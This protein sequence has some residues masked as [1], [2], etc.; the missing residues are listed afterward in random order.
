MKAQNKYTIL[1][2]ERKKSSSKIVLSE[3]KEE[4]FTVI[5]SDEYKKGDKVLCFEYPQLYEVD[6][7]EYFIT[8]TENICA[9]LA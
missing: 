9:K 5:D 7:K 3:V 6:K 1:T 4:F 8:K 2:L